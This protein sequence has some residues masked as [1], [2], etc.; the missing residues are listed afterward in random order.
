MN[1]NCVYDNLT[2][3][4]SCEL[5]ETFSVVSKD[6]YT[7]EIIDNETQETFYVNQTVTY[8]DLIVSFFLLLMFLFFLIKSIFNFIMP[9]SIIIKKRD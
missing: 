4:F 6:F 9:A 5:P 1:F 8:G 2:E 3:T 7:Q